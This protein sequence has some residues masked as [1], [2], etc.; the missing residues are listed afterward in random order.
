MS[1]SL[2]TQ[3]AVLCSYINYFYPAPDSPSLFPYTP[4]LTQLLG[5]SASTRV[6][7]IPAVAIIC[8]GSG[9]RS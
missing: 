4:L 5:L 8:H 7:H 3:Y 1:P 9:I 6:Y 2:G